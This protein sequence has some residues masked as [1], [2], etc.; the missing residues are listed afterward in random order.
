MG[1]FVM[2]AAWS[3]WRGEYMDAG[4]NIAIGVA[5]GGSGAK[6]WE[7]VPLWMKTT[8]CILLAISFSLLGYGAFHSV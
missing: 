8:V 7:D 1:A 4:G 5:L 6:R 3:L 2:V